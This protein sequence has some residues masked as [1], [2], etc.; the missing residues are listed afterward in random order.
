MADEAVLP[1]SC[2]TALDSCQPE[3]AVKLTVEP[4][5]K[6]PAV[7][8]A[9]NPPPTLPVRQNSVV[10]KADIFDQQVE[11]QR[12]DSQKVKKREDSGFVMRDYAHHNSCSDQ[13][14]TN[15]IPVEPITPSLPPPQP[16]RQSRQGQQRIVINLDD[17]NRFT[18]EV[19]V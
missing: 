2:T 1:P 17:K 5:V 13:S 7:V 19:T 14:N 4:T 16:Q 11:K 18:D 6:P 10:R 15:S 12:R 9:V 8:L 3:S